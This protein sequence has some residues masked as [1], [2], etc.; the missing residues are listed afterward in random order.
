M[1]N[2][3]INDSTDGRIERAKDS[4]LGKH[5]SNPSV[6][7]EVGEGVGGIGGA[8]AGAAIGSVA[9]PVGTLI[10]GIAGAMGGWWTGRAIT[11]ATGKLTHDDDNFYRSHYESSPN[12][13]ADRGFEDVRPAYHLGH[14]AAHNPD[15]ASKSWNEVE[16]DLR[17]GWNSEPSKKY[18]EWSS[19]SGYASEGFNRGRSSL[20]STAQRADRAMNTAGNATANTM[21]RAARGAERVGNKA[22]NAADDL[23]DRVDGN[24][25]SKP[26]PD[27]TDSPRRFDSR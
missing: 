4:A 1:D 9:G 3:N 25:A 24:P 8:L 22:A 26:G 20:G 5:D 7:D 2:R 14:I 6:A 15:Y 11:E 21:D 27:A 19:V 16:T 18:G 13:L 23:K 10:G 17:R 12:R